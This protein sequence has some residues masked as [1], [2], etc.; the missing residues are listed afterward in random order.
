MRVLSTAKYVCN[1]SKLGNQGND[2]QVG[3]RTEWTYSETNLSEDFIYFGTPI[4]PCSN[5]EPM[6]VLWAPEYYHPFRPYIQH[7]SKI[8]G[9]P[10]SPGYGYLRK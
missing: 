2:H 9:I 7:P 5:E 3:K 6:A 8:Q 10:L 1:N 4:Y